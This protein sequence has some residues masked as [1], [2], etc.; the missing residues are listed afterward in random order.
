MADLSGLHILC[1]PSWWPSP[2]QPIGGVFFTDYARAF[3][4]AG[5]RVGVVFPDLVSLRQLRGG[6]RASVWPRLSWESLDG[7]PVVRIRGWHTAFGQPARQMGRFLKWQRW[8][9]SEYA[10]RHG[11]PDV[12]HAM[13]AVP[14]GWACAQLDGPLSR[15]IVLTEET[16]PFSLVMDDAATAPY[17]RRALD[18][19]A[20][21]VTVSEH[22]RRDMQAH[23]IQRA[24]E[25]CGNPVAEAFCNR[26]VQA[27]ALSGP[28]RVLYVGR[29]V[30]EK[31]LREFV[32]VIQKHRLETC[33]THRLE[34]GATTPVEWHF[35]GDGPMHAA[36]RETGDATVHLH[37]FCDRARVIQL[38]E[39]SDVLV[40]PT[41]GETFGQSVAEALCMGLPVVTTEGTACAEFID[42]ANG[43]LVR[44]RDAG[45]LAEGIRR[46]TANLREGKY[47]RAAIAERA[48]KRFSGDCVARAYGEW[49]RAA[50][51]R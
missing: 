5:A 39:Q 16:G 31:G 51:Q 44:P 12:V 6:A 19:A 4:R 32:E 13:I 30:Q 40:H 42:E 17:V 9:M 22:A 46:A 37:G 2:E 3:A 33:G 14:A 50:A 34:T 47:N 49:F 26:A 24:I 27:R 43:V 18:A 25:V 45:S 35:A 11:E 36:L 15:R 29:L 7:I 23:G 28:I 8:G 1:V 41:Y 10:L 20:T 48:R 38:V 21:V